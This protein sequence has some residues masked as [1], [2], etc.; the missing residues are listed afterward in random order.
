M[1]D[2]V[3][4]D[5]NCDFGEDYGVYRLENISSILDYVSSVNIA[6]GY[7]AGDPT[8]MRIAVEQAIEKNIKIGAH[9]GF[10]DL[11]G[12]GRRDMDLNAQEIYDI[13][14]YQIGAL[15]AFLNKYDQTLHHVKLHGALYNKAAKSEEISEAVVNAVYDFSPLLKLY[16]LANSI[17]LK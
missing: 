5:L 8:T 7:H 15:S 2:I 3:S 1:I 16:A 13:V 11:V 4:I 12:F 6:C 17:Q 14:T 10:P 9:P